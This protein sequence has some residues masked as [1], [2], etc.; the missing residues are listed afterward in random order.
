LTAN[1]NKIKYLMQLSVNIN[2][3]SEYFIQKKE[4]LI[5]MKKENE[6]SGKISAKNH[7]YIYSENLSIREVK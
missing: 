1:Y 2:K 5:E 6:K 4:M 7:F 3:Y